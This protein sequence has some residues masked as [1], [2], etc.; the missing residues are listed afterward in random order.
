[1]DHSTPRT[2]LITGANAGIGKEVAHQ[3]A[4]DPSVEKIYLACRNE[5]K[6]RKA[7]QELEDKTGRKIFAVILMD[8]SDPESV[9][10]ALRNLDAPVDAVVMNAG[11]LGGKSPMTL[12]RYGVTNIFALQRTRP[13]SPARNHDPERSTKK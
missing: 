11:G 5:I 9:R 8:V 4:S 1:M 13:C 12:T 10:K 3:L 2:I 6:A 7:K